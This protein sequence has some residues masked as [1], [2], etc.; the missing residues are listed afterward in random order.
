MAQ[1]APANVIQDIVQRLKEVEQQT[2]YERL[3]LERDADSKAIRKSYMKQAAKWHPD[4]FSRFDLGP[5]EPKVQRIFA[6]LTEAHTT[7][8]DDNKRAEYDMTLDYGTGKGNT[9]DIGAII[10]AD[11]HFRLGE[12][13]LEHGNYKGALKKFEE[14]C[15]LNPESLRFQAFRAWSFYA[16]LPRGEDNRPA[17]RE[18][19]SECRRIVE[20]AVEEIDDFDM[21]H[22]FLGQMMHI[23]GNSVGAKKEFRTALR[24]NPKNVHAQR[25][26]RLHN[27]REEKKDWFF[28][29]VA[30]MLGIGK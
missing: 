23:E 13:L 3:G 9:P 30:K 16:S 20:Q 15:A 2:M 4:R 21:A 17:N 22:V 24:I 29:K 6:L 25:Q 12:Q 27:M 19:A 1:K 11:N 7:L 14:A 26:L 18:Y 10:G 28:S 8:G 5:Y